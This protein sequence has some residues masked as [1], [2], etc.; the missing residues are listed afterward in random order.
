MPLI[1]HICLMF[2]IS[3]HYHDYGCL[4]SFF[5]YPQITCMT[6]YPLA[7]I[8]FRL[9]DGYINL[10]SKFEWYICN[11][12]RLPK[13]LWPNFTDVHHLITH[14]DQELNHWEEERPTRHHP[15]ECDSNIQSQVSAFYGTLFVPVI[16]G[17]FITQRPTLALR[18][19]KINGLSLSS[20]L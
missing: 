8:G 3:P 10:L 11:G 5:C 13:L 20:P 17:T 18:E 1:S 14:E 6:I 4:P 12:V 15:Q 16:D 7:S 2:H 19:G 9:Q